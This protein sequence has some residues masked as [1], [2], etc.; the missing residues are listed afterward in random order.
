MPPTLPASIDWPAIDAW[1]AAEHPG[2][3]LLDVDA[4]AARLAD[5]TRAPPRLLDARSA[6][7]YAVS[8]LPGAMR[9]DGPDAAT[10][11]LARCAPDAEVVVYCSVG[12]RSARVVAAL[13]SAGRSRVSNLRGSIFA[14]ANRGLPLV[15]AAG[16][17]GHVHPFDEAWGRLLDAGLHARLPRAVSRS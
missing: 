4:L 10:K 13:R 8:R 17:V 15:D 16:A 1:L 9:V 12:V 3:P 11:A 6:A 14:W 2:V 7:E 5:T